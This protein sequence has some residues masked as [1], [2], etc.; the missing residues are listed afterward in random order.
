MNKTVFS[1]YELR[2][3]AFIF[4]GTEKAACVVDCVGTAEEESV[5]RSV[6]K[7]CRGVTNKKRTKGT[8]SGTIKLSLH[9]PWSLWIK[10]HGMDDSDLIEGVYSYGRNSVHPEF[11]LTE[12]VYDEDENL[13]YK[14]YP[15]CVVNTGT[16][17]KIEN[18][19]EEVAEVEMEVGYMPDSYGN[20]MYEALESELKDEAA[21]TA[22]L[23]SF[24][25]EL[26]HVKNA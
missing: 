7:K 21:K 8:G 16:V 20:G 6:S 3:A 2:S 5:T 26:V 4:D 25:S 9:C 13:K 22:W 15:N 11:C 12:K 1:E 18:G 14:A 23:E 10:S 24:N 17:V 19:A